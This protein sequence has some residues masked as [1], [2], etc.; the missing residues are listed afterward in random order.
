MTD[1]RGV[2]VEVDYRAMTDD[3]LESH[4]TAIREVQSDRATIAAEEGLCA[5]LGQQIAE[6]QAEIER[7]RERAA[8]AREREGI[9][10]PQEED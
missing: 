3:E 8:Q 7:I 5:S 6:S 4:A 1:G 10:P 2:Q 9:N